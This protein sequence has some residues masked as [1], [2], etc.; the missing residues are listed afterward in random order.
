[1]KI[2]RATPARL[3]SGAWGAKIEGKI[4]RRIQKGQQIQIRTRSGKSWQATIA[5]VV[6]RGVDVAFVATEDDGHGRSRR[7]NNG[8]GYCSAC[9]HDADTC[10]DMDCTCS[11]CGGMMR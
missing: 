1:M 6:W 4:A 7:S 11:A 9:G 2:V 3:R 8:R 5:K 10:A